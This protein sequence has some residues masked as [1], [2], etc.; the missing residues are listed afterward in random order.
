MSVGEAPAVRALRLVG[1]PEPDDAALALSARDGDAGAYG[2]IWDRYHGLVRRILR[3]VLGPA[4]DV[5]VEDEVQEVFLRFYRMRHALRKPEALRSFLFGIALRVARSELRTARVR[6][7]LR[8]TKD[9]TIEDRPSPASDTEAREALMR[10]YEILDRL[11]T[12]SR[13][14][15]VLHHVEGLGLVEVAQALGVSLAT[16]KRRLSR[17][18][19]KVLRL[20]EQDAALRAYVQGRLGGKE[21]S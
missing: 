16:V 13:L 7:W 18:S 6:S 17:A 21:P 10:L 1:A 14:A 9:G 15:F 11:D 20:A 19:G 2:A 8:L 12:E 5:D 4:R 3:R